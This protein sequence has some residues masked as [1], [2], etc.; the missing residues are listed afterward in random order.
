MG[1]NRERFERELH[2]L[3]GYRFKRLLVVGS[4]AEILSSQ[5]HSNIKPNAVLATA[6][7]FEVRYDL[8]VVFVPTARAGARLVKRWA[9]YFAR[10]TVETVNDLWRAK[11]II[12]SSK[13]IGTSVRIFYP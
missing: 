8:P 3:R 5:Y 9:F 1:E 4:E 7:A 12:I 11:L 2:R 6:Y 13:E 10:Q